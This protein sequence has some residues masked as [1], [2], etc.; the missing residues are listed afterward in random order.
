MGLTG[1]TIRGTLSALRRD[2]GQIASGSSPSPSEQAINS[3]LLDMEV[4]T[5]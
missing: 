5:M 3:P 2:T 1:I 4:R